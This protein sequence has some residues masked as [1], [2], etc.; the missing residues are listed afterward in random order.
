MQYMTTKSIKSRF[1]LPNYTIREILRGLLVPKF[2]P[3]HEQSAETHYSRLCHKCML[4]LRSFHQACL[5]CS[6]PHI[7]GRV[8]QSCRQGSAIIGS[9][10]LVRLNDLGRNILWHS[11]FYGNI[12]YLDDLLVLYKQTVDEWFQHYVSDGYEF[13][14]VPEAGDSLRLRGYHHNQ[15]LRRY[16]QRRYGLKFNNSLA[17]AKHIRQTG[18]SRL[19]RIDMRSEIYL[20]RPLRSEKI[21]IIDDVFTTGQ[22]MRNIATILKESGAKKVVGIS[23]FRK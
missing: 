15:Y 19:Q 17:M 20:L 18:K 2:C 16:L 3:I 14:F 22:T 9:L 21:V 5:F 7:A 8:C 23:M 4:D 11:K 10:S 6:R 12:E 1:R 13:I